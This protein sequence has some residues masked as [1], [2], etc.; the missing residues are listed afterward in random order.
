[1]SMTLLHSAPGTTVR[2]TFRAMGCGIEV[3]LVQGGSAAAH[4]IDVALA[5]VEAQFT[6]YEAALS[7]FLP[8]SELS[9]LNRAAGA[10][11]FHASSL[12]R[13]ITG[14][15]LAAAAET[16]GIFD[17]TLATVL[18]RLGYDRPFPLPEAFADGAL[19]V[20]IP[21]HRFGA[22]RDVAADDLAET[23]ELPDDM[24]LD[25]GGI[26]KGWTVDRVVAWLREL[27]GIA[28][29]FVNAGGDLRVWGVAPE[30]DPAWTVGVE[31]PASIDDDCARLDVMDAAVATSSTA[32]RRWRRGDAWVHHLLDPRTGKPAMTDLAAVTVIGPSAAWAEVHA[33]VALLHGAHAGRDYLERQREY[34]GLLVAADGTQAV[35]RGMGRYRA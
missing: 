25:F 7:R 31:D 18:V 20:R 3:Q 32:Y 11:P 4:E 21:P 8:A 26:G 17:P 9:T 35:T 34:D 33:K 27:S 29:G 14:D 19:P 6:A 2:H 10:G 12:L 24:A 30:D 1:M 28:G 15:A 13:A 5:G 22:W 23:I 16:G